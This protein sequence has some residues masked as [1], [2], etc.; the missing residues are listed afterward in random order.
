MRLVSLLPGKEPAA[1]QCMIKEVMLKDRPGYEALSY[2]WGGKS[3][4]IGVIIL[5]GRQF[6]VTR[7]LEIALRHLRLQHETRDLWIDA[8]SINQLDHEEKG[9][10]V[11]KMKSIYQSASRVLVWL[12]EARENSDLA[13]DL[14]PRIGNV[15]LDEIQMEIQ[16]R[17]TEKGWDALLQLF[18]RPWWSRS[19]VLQEVVAARSDPLVGCGH[20]WLSWSVFK[21]AHGFMCKT[22]SSRVLQ[23]MTS[24]A[25]TLL[26][27]RNGART[28][29]RDLLQGTFSFQATDPRDKVYSLLGLVHEVER[30]ALTPDYSKSVQHV[31]IGIAQHLLRDDINMLCFNT[32]SP[33]HDLPSWVPDWSWSS[34]RWPIWMPGTYNATGKFPSH[35]AGRFGHNP[36]TFTLRG[37]AV[38][39][40]SMLDETS[41]IEMSQPATSDSTEEEVLDNI[42]STL[43]KAIKEQPSSNLRSLDP[44]ISDAL[45]RTLVTDRSLIGNSHTPGPKSPAPENYGQMFEVFRGHSPVPTDFQPNMLPAHR[46][47]EY[48]KLFVKSMQLGNQRFFVTSG[49]RIGLGPYDIQKDD[50][51]VVLFGGDMPFILRQKDAYHRLIGPSY[52]HGREDAQLLQAADTDHRQLGEMVRTAA[53]LIGSTSLGSRTIGTKWDE[54]AQLKAEYLQGDKR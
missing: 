6:P 52:V 45:W 1:V 5:E 18:R 2:T 27:A 4:F 16:D 33:Y 14:V 32:N 47:Q 36:S 12:G 3:P 44:E 13:M 17:E 48:T 24:P 20:K 23:T 50:L 15:E 22:T 7:N 11:Q 42:E 19:W 54:E 25:Q 34:R 31:Y 51:V 9:P 37:I 8:L 35:S 29:M 21:T 49:G 43:R 26:L 39:D 10:Q 46:K 38:D 28:S 53:S 41:R 30:L 40:I